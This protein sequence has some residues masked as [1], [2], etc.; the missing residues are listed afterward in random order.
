MNS[1]L[2]AWLAEQGIATSYL[3][4][5]GQLTGLLFIGVIL[6]FSFYLAKQLFLVLLHAVVL[7]SENKW[8]DLFLEH[9]VFVHLALLLPLLL[10]LFL[11]PL[12]LV[13]DDTLT[14]RPDS[15]R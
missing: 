15:T 6:F 3:P 5:S 7:N 4:L 9:H 10:L 12:V 1:S 8:D 11:T 2:V 13:P 14:V